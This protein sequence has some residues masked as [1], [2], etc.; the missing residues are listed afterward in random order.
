MAVATVWAGGTFPG[1]LAGFFAV[2]ALGVGFVAGFFGSAMSGHRILDEIADILG[3]D[4]FLDPFAGA[5]PA[6]AL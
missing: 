5:H 1:A 6:P 3:N 2:S 4:Q